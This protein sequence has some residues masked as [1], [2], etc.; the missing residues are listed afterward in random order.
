MFIIIISSSSSN[1]FNVVNKPSHSQNMNTLLACVIL[2]NELVG[3]YQI[4]SWS[5]YF[6]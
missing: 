6:E 1:F 4:D 2:G 5:N 3:G